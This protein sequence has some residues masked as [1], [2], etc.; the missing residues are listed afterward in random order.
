MYGTA[1]Y[2][3]AMY[4]TAMLCMALLTTTKHPTNELLIDRTLFVTEGITIYAK[5][6]HV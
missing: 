5:V 4:G 1:M 3:T 6:L 2:G